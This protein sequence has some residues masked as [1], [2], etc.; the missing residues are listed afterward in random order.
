LGVSLVCGNMPLPENILHITWIAFAV[1]K[2][3]SGEEY[4]IHNRFEKL[5][6]AARM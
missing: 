3:K 4:L 5:S 1:V 2:R 6:T